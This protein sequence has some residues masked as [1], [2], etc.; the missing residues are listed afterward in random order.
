MSSPPRHNP[1]RQSG[2]PLDLAV[3]DVSGPL[4]LPT[5]DPTSFSDPSDNLSEPP[6]TSTLPSSSTLLTTSATTPP[7]SSTPS[8]TSTRSTPSG[9]VLST[10]T[11]SFVTDFNGSPTTILTPAVTAVHTATSRAS[12]HASVIAGSAAGSL[13]VLVIVTATLFIFCRRRRS[14]AL[15]RPSRLQSPST[16]IAGSEPRMSFISPPLSPTADPEDPFA[17]GRSSPR[18]NVGNV[19]GDGS[20]ATG[21]GGLSHA[22]LAALATEYDST[23]H[24]S[25]W[26]P[27][28]RASQQSNPFALPPERVHSALIV[29]DI[30][31]PPQYN[32][33]L[34]LSAA[35]TPA[36]PT[37]T[38]Q[39]VLGKEESGPEGGRMKRR[40]TKRK[41]VPALNISIPDSVGN[42]PR[43]ETRQERLPSLPPLTPSP[44]LPMPTQWLNRSP[45]AFGMG[46]TWLPA[47]ATAI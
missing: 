36:S 41:P 23:F 24:E 10:F 3:P 9:S 4:T 19:S 6:F 31:G 33:A 34:S 18:G 46:S 27:P 30:I 29:N 44:P 32:G 15:S 22:L 7:P 28:S 26:P 37:P 45:D 8:I 1:F 16:F 42:Q 12:T 21:G 39:S 14:R 11:S 38:I 2:S 47:Q 13:A 35:A 40:G 17:S 25:I 5:L 20:D 43:P